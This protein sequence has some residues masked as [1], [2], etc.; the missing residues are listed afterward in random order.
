MSYREDQRRKATAMRD[1][2]F[3]DPG[4]GYFFKKERDFV[5]QDATLNLWAGIREDAI[6][7]F[8][9]N[10]IAWWM[11]DE[12]TEPTGHLLSSQV[13]CLNHL[14][15]VR[16]RKDAATAI[17]KNICAGIDQAVTV[18]NGFVEFEVIGNRN[19]LNERS[20]T[21]GA[22]ATSVDAVM[23][24]EK[25]P[26][27]NILFLIEWKYTEEYREENKY[28]PAR[29]E[30]Y[31]P[32][33][34][35]EHSPILVEDFSSLYYEPFY[36]L[37]RQTLLGWRMVQR[38][39]YQCDEWIHLHVIPEDNAEM[40]ERITSPGLRSRGDNISDVWKSVLR[41][42]TRY[43]TIT[44]EEFLRPAWGCPDTH[45]IAAYLEKRYWI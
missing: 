35:E 28:I 34:E 19:H 11:G 31:N 39:D 4:A 29:Y 44:P 38:R 10:S 23:V 25:K 13:A 6:E 3:R 42:P 14:Y 9:E 17:L 32:L 36:Q 21:R 45:S 2:L 43:M 1:A 24:G 26:G 15:F 5:L 22:N 40:R 8:K 16:Q 7:Y 12:N 41:E 30:I 27:S 20:H 18:D 33:L 37:M